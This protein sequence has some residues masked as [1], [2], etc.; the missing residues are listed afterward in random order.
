MEAVINI[1]SASE[2]EKVQFTFS[3]SLQILTAL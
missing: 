1:S 2:G 3:K